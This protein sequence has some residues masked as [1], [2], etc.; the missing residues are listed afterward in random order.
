[1]TLFYWGR[2]TGDLGTHGLPAYLGQKLG[3]HEL[4]P[5]WAETVEPMDFGI[6]TELGTCRLLAHS[7]QAFCVAR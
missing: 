3:T 2:Y 6:E 5:I 4:P 7:G 1:M